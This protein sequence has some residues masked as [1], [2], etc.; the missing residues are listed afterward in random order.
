MRGSF[1]H[2][3]EPGWFCTSGQLTRRFYIFVGADFSFVGAGFSRVPYG[4]STGRQ[5]DDADS[6]A[7]ARRPER[8]LPSRLKPAPTT[9]GEPDRELAG[10][11]KIKSLCR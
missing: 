7:R 8:R 6:N 1:S 4:V 3:R 11:S 9:E 2:R 5:P 10:G